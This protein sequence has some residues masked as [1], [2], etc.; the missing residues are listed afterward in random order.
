MRYCRKTSVFRM[1]L[2]KMK[3]DSLSL[4]ERSVFLHE[5]AAAAKATCRPTSAVAAAT[6]PC[7]FAPAIA[8]GPGGPHV[9]E[10]PAA[11]FS[12]IS[13]LSSARA[14]RGSGATVGVASSVTFTD[15]AS[16]MQK[17]Y[18][19]VPNSNVGAGGWGSCHVLEDIA[20]GCRLCGKFDGHCDISNPASRDH[21]SRELTAMSRL[22][23]PNV[24][25]AFGL[26][27]GP[28]DRI[29]CLLMPLCDRDFCS[30]VEG[31][32]P[33]DG[34]STNVEEAM[35]L[36]WEERGSI[37]QVASG[38]AHTHA[39]EIV[40][41]DLKPENVLVQEGPF[42]STFLISD[43]GICRSSNRDGGVIHGGRV[44]PDEV[45]S[46]KYRPLY[47]CGTISEISVHSSMD[48]WALGCITFEVG[49]WPN[50]RWRGSHLHLLRLFSGVKMDGSSMAWS[51]RDHRV[52]MFCPRVLRPLVITATAAPS[53]S[54]L[55][56][57]AKGLATS[58]IGMATF[59][60]S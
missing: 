6:S 14:T 58:L 10:E 26:C 53:G 13:A 50:P 7:T 1:D 23:H 43:F 42:A 35:C 60:R 45:N 25:K 57:T 20:T 38:L 39:R 15:I 47:L 22:C 21:L 54:T 59:P 46:M 56:A 41:M 52:K 44:K 19:V 3:F 9:I 49:S 18:N 12:P 5:A 2:L 24:L 16:G 55:R 37:I 27:Y 8:G 32:P 11:S 40:H 34:A 33:Y 36:R 48:V 28:G 51:A 17:V 29:E 4:D 31:R 30:W